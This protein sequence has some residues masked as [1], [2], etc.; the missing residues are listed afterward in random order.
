MFILNLIKSKRGSEKGRE[1]FYKLLFP[2]QWPQQPGLG[3]VWIRRQEVHLGLFPV[4]DR[5]S[6]GKNA[7]NEK[8]LIILPFK[9]TFKI[10]YLVKRKG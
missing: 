5:G 4:G 10:D 7:K 8:L 3:Q 9:D 6:N 2:H 1:I